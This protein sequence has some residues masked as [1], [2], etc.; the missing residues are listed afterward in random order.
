M[1]QL[2]GVA[3]ASSL[4][5]GASR[6]VG[7]LTDI[8]SRS[9]DTATEMTGCAQ[10][11]GLA[12]TS[13]TQSARN[14]AGT[15]QKKLPP[16]NETLPSWGAVGASD[17]NKKRGRGKRDWAAE[18]SLEVQQFKDSLPTNQL[19]WGAEAKT[20]AKDLQ[21]KTKDMQIRIRNSNDLSEVQELKKLIKKVNF[22]IAL[23]EVA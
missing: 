4:A 12:Q 5:E 14:S 18:I 1:G 22:I 15:A 11:P 20:K 13:A 10:N 6:G 7:Q 8:A 9:Q 21:A 16:T 19:Y 17:K 3:A 23:I 2:L